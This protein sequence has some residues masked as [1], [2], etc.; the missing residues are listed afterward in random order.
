MLSDLALHSPLIKFVFAYE[1]ITVKS[2]SI[3]T[4]CYVN[5]ENIVGKRENDG[6]QHFFFF[7]TIFS[8]DFFLAIKGGPSD[9]GT[10]I[11]QKKN[12]H[13]P[14]AFRF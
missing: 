3:D 12:P 4:G 5:V 14:K 7:P 13:T 11:L 8:K 10:E 2:D 6:F 1:R 9:L